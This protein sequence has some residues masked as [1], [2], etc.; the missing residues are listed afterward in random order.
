MSQGMRGAERAAHPARQRSSSLFAP[1]PAPCPRHGPVRPVI[2]S[3][4]QP[5][6]DGTRGE[7]PFQRNGSTHVP[8][9]GCIR[10]CCPADPG[11]GCEAAPTSASAGGWVGR[12]RPAPPVPRR[13]ARPP[14]PPRWR[15]PPKV[16]P[17]PWH[18]GYIR[19]AAH[20]AHGASR[21][22]AP[23]VHRRRRA[24]EHAVHPAPRHNRAGAVHPHANTLAEATVHLWVGAAGWGS[25]PFR[26]RTPGTIAKAFVKRAV[27]P[28]AHGASRTVAPTVHRTRRAVGHRGASC[29]GTP[30]R[31]RRASA[32]EHLRRG[33]GAPHGRCGWGP[34][35]PP[36]SGRLAR[37]APATVAT[38][39]ARP[40]TVHLTVGGCAARRMPAHR[41]PVRPLST[42][43][44]CRGPAARLLPASANAKVRRSSSPRR[45]PARP[46]RGA[47]QAALL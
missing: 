41:V 40:T 17:A 33:G 23:K 19:P 8:A 46:A 27:R 32:R 6:R 9:C 25:P 5:L 21:T 34:A 37:T 14:Q 3:S 44:L 42:R 39:A 45:V 22:V 20:P 2:V 16:H 38:V 15:T 24:V 7:L 1:E 43:R 30:S 18:R 13:G 26:P 10:R 29:T 47:P 31:G 35:R 36:I 11:S 4:R 12:L 28:A